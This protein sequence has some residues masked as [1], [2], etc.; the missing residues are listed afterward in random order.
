MSNA[1]HLSVWM[2]IRAC[3][4]NAEF[5]STHL[6]NLTYVTACVQYIANVWN[7]LNVPGL[8]SFLKGDAFMYTY[9]LYCCISCTMSGY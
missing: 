2:Q 3:I 7:L 4:E 5:F 8:R 9:T 1:R 6:I